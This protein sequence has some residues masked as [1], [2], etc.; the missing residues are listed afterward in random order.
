MKKPNFGFK[1]CE[2]LLKLTFKPLV[3]NYDSKMTAAPSDKNAICVSIRERCGG[4]IL[5]TSKTKL[6][7]TVCFG[8]LK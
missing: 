5:K 7:Q 6:K 1:N 2:H 3:G 4:V 8:K